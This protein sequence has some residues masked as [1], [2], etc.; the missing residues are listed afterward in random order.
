MKPLGVM[1]GVAYDEPVLEVLDG[2]EKAGAAHTELWGHP[3]HANLE[4]PNLRYSLEKLQWERDLNIVAYH[5]PGADEWDLSE[6]G[7]RRQQ[8][9]DRLVRHLSYLPKLG[10]HR[11]VVHPGGERPDDDEAEARALEHAARSLEV[12]LEEADRSGVRICVENTLPHHLGG[13]LSDLKQLDKAVTEP[14]SVTLDTSHANLSDGVFPYIDAF[15][16]RIVHTHLSD[17]HGDHDDHFPPGEGSIPFPAI[18]ERLAE[19]APIDYWMMEVLRL[20]E[21]GEHSVGKVATR[22]LEGLRKCLREVP[23]IQQQCA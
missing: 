14:F 5:P 10:I 23:E 6:P 9:L 13:Q 17:N 12:L 8:A 1:T 22:A 7:E 3:D 16:N 4:D 20:P 18:L 11:M 21:D 19:T 2:L 15:E